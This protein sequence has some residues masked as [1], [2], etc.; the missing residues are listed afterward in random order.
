M[1]AFFPFVYYSSFSYWV[2]RNSDT[3]SSE[4]L[5]RSFSAKF[6]S[7]HITYISNFLGR[8][9]KDQERKDHDQSRSIYLPFLYWSLLFSMASFHVDQV[10]LS[11]LSYPV[12][13]VNIH[14][15]SALQEDYISVH[16]GPS[17]GG[18][19]GLS[20]RRCLKKTGYMPA[21]GK[22]CRN[23]H[24]PSQGLPLSLVLWWTGPSAVL[25][26]CFWVDLCSIFMAPFRKQKRFCKSIW[27]RINKVWRLKTCLAFKGY[28][29]YPNRLISQTFDKNPY[30]G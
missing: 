25:R 9:T 30:L 4:E 15:L 1:W 8:G 14:L 16:N 26:K 2:Q 6:G 11:I 5:S 7:C 20:C 3:G 23:K 12:I 29:E 13:C 18:R 28:V 19:L 24:K 27:Y 17:E 10:T 22:D 21:D